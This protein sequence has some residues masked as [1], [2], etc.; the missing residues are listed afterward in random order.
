MTNK[1]NHIQTSLENAK[2]DLAYLFKNI[3]HLKQDKELIEK[4][5]E[6]IKKQEGIKNDRIMEMTSKLSKAIEELRNKED[7]VKQ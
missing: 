4:E 2:T 3:K 6:H 1:I 5:L 7:E